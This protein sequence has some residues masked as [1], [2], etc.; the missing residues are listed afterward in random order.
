MTQ[1]D[2]LERR[3]TQALERISRGVDAWDPRALAALEDAAEPAEPAAAPEP[4]ED[5]GAR[6]EELQAEL[7]RLRE[8][9]EDEKLANAQ[10]EERLRALHEKRED[11]STNLMAQVA[12]QREGLSQ[13]DAEMHRL[14]QTNDALRQSNDALRQANAQGVGEPHLINTAMLTELEAIR[15]DRATEAAEAR[16]VLDALAPL[17]SDAAGQAPNGHEEGTA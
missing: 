6:A 1:I 13:L 9:L 15:A 7:D 10:L 2:E 16:A 11:D 3:I 12:A 8:A 14:R 4:A 5:S 17:L